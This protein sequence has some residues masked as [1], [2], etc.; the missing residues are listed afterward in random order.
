MKSLKKKPSNC[1]FLLHRDLFSHC[2]KLTS[3]FTLSAVGLIIPWEC[4]IG[5]SQHK[6]LLREEAG[7]QSRE[8]FIQK[9]SLETFIKIWSFRLFQICKEKS[10]LQTIATS[11]FK[12]I[13]LF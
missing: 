11:I 9:I 4:D 8:E 7:K 1:R 12:K 5:S 2:W 3:L 13:Y 6:P 10:Y